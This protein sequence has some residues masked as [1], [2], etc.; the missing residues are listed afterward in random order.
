[1]AERRAKAKEAADVAVYGAQVAGDIAR[2]AIEQKASLIK[3]AL[4]CQAAPAFAAIATEMI[5]RYQQATVQ[6]RAVHIEGFSHQIAL[7]SEMTRQMDA[8]AAKGMLT[9]G[10]LAEAKQAVASFVG[11]DMASLANAV[12]R[13]MAAIDAHTGRATDHIAE[14]TNK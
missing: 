6:L 3:G 7:R 12:Q 14:I 8:L 5:A 9:D 1:M 11:S 10:E 4:V 2:Q 13:A